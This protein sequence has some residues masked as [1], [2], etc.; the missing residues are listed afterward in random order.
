MIPI[1]AFAV[2]DA[3]LPKDRQTTALIR[4][5]SKTREGRIVLAGVA[6]AV[7]AHLLDV[8]Q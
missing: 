2:V 1:L 3:L 7:L 8:P 5:L 4:N 6:V